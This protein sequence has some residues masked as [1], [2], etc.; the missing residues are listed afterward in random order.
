MGLE[1][2]FVDEEGKIKRSNPARDIAYFWPQ[3]LK[4]ARNG[5]LKENW[6]STISALV[7]L[8]NTDFDDSKIDESTL[9]ETHKRL[10]LFC[11]AALKTELDN[12]IKALVS[13]NFFEMPLMARVIVLAVVGQVCAG[14]FWAGIRASA[15]KGLIPDEIS[16]VIKYSEQTMIESKYEGV[17]LYKIPFLGN[18]A[19]KVLDWYKKN[20]C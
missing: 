8:N 4:A 12:P 11:E 6:E 17:Q 7:L 9:L 2:K 15:P 13:V 1:V 5:L 10:C 14:A 19:R 16:E 20:L 3:L 18:L